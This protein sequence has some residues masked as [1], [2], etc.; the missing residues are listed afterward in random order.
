[1]VE[2]V[3]QFGED[4]STE[5]EPSWGSSDDGMGGASAHGGHGASH[6]GFRRRFIL[7]KKRGFDK[8]EEKWEKTHSKRTS[9]PP[10]HSQ[11]MIEK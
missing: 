2:Y 3:D 6:W 10:S 1:M 8:R 9:L 5:S 4:R 11:D 7:G